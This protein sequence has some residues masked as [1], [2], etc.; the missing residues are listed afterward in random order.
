M[1]FLNF[2]L[3]PSLAVAFITFCHFFRL[4]YH[5]ARAN[6]EHGRV[7]GASTMAVPINVCQVP[8]ITDSA[9]CRM[10]AN[11]RWDGKVGVVKERLFEVTGCQRR[12]VPAPVIWKAHTS[13]V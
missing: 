6:I 5:S 3:R 9:T 13:Y 12:A 2:L 8:R 11:V 1:Q 7:D 10:A 4:P